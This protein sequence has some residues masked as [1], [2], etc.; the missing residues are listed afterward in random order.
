MFVLLMAY[1]VIPDPEAE[2]FY[3]NLTGSQKNVSKND[4][5]LQQ[6]RK[7]VVK[8]ILFNEGAEL[9]KLRLECQDA[10]ILFIEKDGKGEI[11]E[12]MYDVIGRMQE[13]LY[14]VL[15]D[16]RLAFGIPNHFF[17][18]EE[19]EVHGQK[20]PFKD[21][22]AVPMQT[23]N[24]F[25]ADSAVYTFRHEKF[26]ADQVQVFRYTLPSHILMQPLSEA[27]PSMTAFAAKV[28]FSLKNKKLNL[29]ASQF[30]GRL[31]LPERD[32]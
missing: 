13:K 6:Q 3:H 29:D 17:Q 20:I 32:L 7:G 25:E 18:M 30:K 19:L 12:R 2:A 24:Y 8:E 23:I 14:Y 15:P 5:H 10:E 22:G 9:R 4:Y 28:E 1:L 16:G 27:S 21:S 31:E 26:M 11:Q